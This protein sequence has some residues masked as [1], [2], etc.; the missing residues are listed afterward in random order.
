ME[1]VRVDQWMWS[2]RLYKTRS[3]ATKAC[4]GG[5][6]RINDNA[7]KPAAPVRIG[8]RVETHEGGRVRVLEVREL[9]IKRV[10]A[11]RAAEC[12]VDHSPP[13]PPRDP[14][15]FVRSVG[16]GRPTKRDRRLLDRLRG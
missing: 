11:P 16:S 5:H 3:E 1:T 13:P 14:A 8:D 2:V 6:V 10:G 4:Q 12:F 15:V 9:I 7:A